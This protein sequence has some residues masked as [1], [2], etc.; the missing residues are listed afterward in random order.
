[1]N[2]KKK[3]FLFFQEL[4][5]KDITQT[6]EKENEQRHTKTKMFSWGRRIE[7]K[8]GGIKSSGNNTDGV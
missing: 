8:E 1:M 2:Q 5:F 4:N 3:C 7:N 6:K